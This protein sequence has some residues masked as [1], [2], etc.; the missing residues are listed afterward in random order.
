MLIPNNCR[1]DGCD[2]PRTRF[3]VF[4]DEH[5]NEELIR[6]GLAL[7]TPVDPC[8]GMKHKCIQRVDAE[9]THAITREEVLTS[10]FDL[11]IHA[12][13]QR[14]ERCWQETLDALPPDVS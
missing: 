5:H 12:A 6:V 13:M 9:R 1:R 3:S 4:C 10:L 14:L 7:E 2:R 11:F 8:E